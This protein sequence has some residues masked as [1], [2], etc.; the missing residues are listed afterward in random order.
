MSHSI[1]VY[2]FLLCT[3]LHALHKPR[4]SQKIVNHRILPV[5]VLLRLLLVPM[6]V[7]L[8][9]RIEDI[10]EPLAGIADF[11]H[12]GQISASIAVIWRTPNRA[13]SVI[14]E[15]LIPLLAQL[16]RPQDMRHAVDL[17]EL[18]NDLRAERIPRA[19]RGERELV[20]VGIRIRPHQVCH[21]AL[22]RDLAIPVQDL[23]L[24]DGVDGRREAAVDAE[25][26]VVD[27]HAQGQE[28]E[29]VGEVVPDVGVAV[30]PGAFGVKPIRL[31]DAAGFVVSA[32]KMY[33]MRISQFETD[34]EG[35][36]F[37]AE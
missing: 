24:I 35:D 21:G 19:T 34:E 33:A 1:A 17:E 3:K 10:E 12:T 7:V 2:K 29:H 20:S 9:R 18:A 27:H 25:D 23:D 22:V 13:Q 36:C 26:L 4:V 28:I 16:M 14:V 5:F 15:H 8:R 37:D 31:R 32:D 11:E 30:L 6:Y